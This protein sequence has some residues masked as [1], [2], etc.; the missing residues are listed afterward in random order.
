VPFTVLDV[1]NESAREVYQHRL[2]LVRPDLHIA[3]RGQTPPEDAK[4]LARLVSGH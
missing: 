3:W 2:L 1:D 4:A